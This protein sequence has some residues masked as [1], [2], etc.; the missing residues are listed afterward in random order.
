MWAKMA[1]VS[2]GKLGDGG[3]EDADFYQAKLATAR[4]FMARLLPQTGT[5]FSTLMA[6]KKP[7]M[8][9]AEAAF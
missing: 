8:E 5:Y 7:L 2:L 9:M 3:A 1:R 4:F 6:G